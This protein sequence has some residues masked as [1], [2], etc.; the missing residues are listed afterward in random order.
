MVI[1]QSRLHLADLETGTYPMQPILDYVRRHLADMDLTSVCEVGCGVGRLIGEIS[2]SHPSAACYGIDYSYQMLRQAKRY[3]LEGGAI[4]VKDEYLGYPSSMIPSH[5]PLTNL[6]LLMAKASDLPF[7][8]QSIDVVITSFL[9]DRLA[10]PQ[11]A[12]LEWYRVIRPGGK[13][14]IATPL[15]WQTTEQRH[16]LGD[17]QALDH[18]LQDI[19]LQLLDHQQTLIK[20]P[21]DARGNYVGWQTEV[22]VV[23]KD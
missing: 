7:R 1:R 16:D 14:I 23:E 5:T 17:W 4:E 11:A 21:I 2:Q 15:N 10:D 6:N 8:D 13:I 19:G 12:L 22:V 3:W 20:E 18:L 9:L